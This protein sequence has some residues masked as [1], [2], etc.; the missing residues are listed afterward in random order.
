M[1]ENKYD[2][3]TKPQTLRHYD[4]FTHVCCKYLDSMP[5][6]ITYKSF[7]DCVKFSLDSIEGFDLL[8]EADKKILMACVG[9]NSLFC[10]F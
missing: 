10:G 9:D 7:S 1:L 4:V 5:R 2:F 3:I 6:N 8:S